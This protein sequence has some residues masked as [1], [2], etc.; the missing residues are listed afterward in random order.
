VTRPGVAA[1]VVEDDPDHALLIRRTLERQEPPIGVT[2]ARDGPAC[3]QALD[4]RAWS[5]ILLDYSL[6]RMSG[7]DVLAEIRRR[8][9]SV[10]VIIVTGQGDERVAVQAMKTG[11]TDYL[12]KTTG[13]LATLPTVISKVLQQ[14]E[15]TQENVRLYEEAQRALRE[16][17]AAQEKL[18]RGETL[19]AL[20][21][22]A[23]GAAHHLNN[24]FAVICGRVELMLARPDCEPLRRPLEIVARAARDGVEVVRRIQQFARIKDT[25][26]R[27]PIDLNAVAADVVEFTR[28]RW[29]DTARMAGSAI[30]VVLESTEV[31]AVSGHAGPLRE[32]V[33]NLMLNAI[34]AMPPSGG[35]IV[36]RT[37][38][39]ET[40][41]ALAVTDTGV[42]M[43]EEVRRRAHEPF[44]TT[45]GPKSTGLGLSVNYGIVQRYGGDL[46]IESEPGRGTTVTMTL[47][48]VSEAVM[49]PAAAPPD[50]AAHS[51]D[52]IVIDDEPAIRDV[53]V[54]MLEA[55]GH[56][57][58]ACAGALDAAGWD[59]LGP[60]PDVVISDL[61]MPGATGWDV[62]IEAKRR[63]PGVLVG[64][65]T[66]WGTTAEPPGPEAGRAVDF[67]LGK[68]LTVAGLREALAQAAACRT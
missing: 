29:Q 39:T 61:G 48:L 11:A 9:V 17:E 46:V 66:G 5:V 52:V 34:D 4:T 62:A 60:A 57:V 41:V 28:P 49:P 32:V 64:I 7:I 68:P 3:L 58:R 19:R 16:L 67:L 51:L 63:W 59:A 54:D 23:S 26:G 33:T 27:E 6:P 42:G 24:L 22:L 21:E 56:T 50:S 65:V 38:R 30:E 1:L 37:W 15:L 12:M 31:P 20:G 18:I 40:H 13:Y 14:H 47:P 8:G 35:R 43:P 36:I 25:E 55:D 45:K 53:I 44:F 10:P 2:V